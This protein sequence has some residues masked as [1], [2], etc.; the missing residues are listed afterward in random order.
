MD[1]SGNLYILDQS[2]HAIRRLTT[3]G[4]I[5]TFAGEPNMPGM[6]DGTAAAARFRLPEGIAIDA[7]NNL[8]VGDTGNH[9]IRKISPAAVVTTLAGACGTAGMSNGSGSSARFDR[10]SGLVADNEGNLYVMDRGNFAIREITPLGEVTTHAGQPGVRGTA[11]GASGTAALDVPGS[12]IVRASDGTLYFTDHHA[13]RAVDPNGVVSTRAGSITEE[14]SVDASVPADARFRRP[15]GLLLDTAGN[16]YVADTGNSQIRGIAASGQVVTFVGV[17]M[18]FGYANSGA[19]PALFNEPTGMLLVNGSLLV[20][21]SRNHAIRVVAGSGNVS[22]LGGG[23][24]RNGAEEGTGAAARFDGPDGIVARAD[25]SLFVVDA[26]NAVIRRI[27]SQATSTFAG[28]KGLPGTVD[29]APG[30]GRLFQPT[31]LAQ[32]PDGTLVVADGSAIRTIA[33]DGTVTTLAGAVNPATDSYLDDTGTSAR[34]IR[35]RGLTVNAAGEIFVADTGSCTIRKIDAAAVVTTVAGSNGDC[36]VQDGSGSG[37]R[38]LNPS[39]ITVDGSGN[40][41]VADVGDDGGSVLRKIAPDG[42]VTTLAGV[43]GSPGRD[44]GNGTAARFGEIRALALAADGSLLVADYGT[45]TIRKVTTGGDVTL[46]LGGDNQVGERTG[47][48]AP[49]PGAAKGLAVQGS[50]LYWTTDHAVMRGDPQ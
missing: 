21:D 42:T 17:E 48:T 34:I 35:P 8:Y 50:T 25:G 1:S 43:A 44:N 18:T 49:L 13:V 20:A 24:S 23:P 14:E 41:Y 16:I 45:G 15:Q 39:A 28:S 36:T 3:D 30:T 10:P 11:N 2:A 26:G 27:V 29:G 7:A 22:T 4:R 6:S 33:A 46:V 32:M 40:L 9:C 5:G 12:G 38:F 47:S 31:D 37:A 19:T